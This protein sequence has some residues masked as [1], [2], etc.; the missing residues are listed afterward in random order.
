[1]WAGSRE[2]PTDGCIG[3]GF[4]VTGHC[5]TTHRGSFRRTPASVCQSKRGTSSGTDNVAWQIDLEANGI[6]PSASLQGRLSP[7][8]GNHHQ[9]GRSDASA[10]MAIVWPRPWRMSRISPPPFNVVVIA[11]A[12]GW[13]TERVTC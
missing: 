9:V 6:S 7:G 1:M 12:S 5:R 11:M 8:L 10:T 4:Q 13:I 3:L 2:A